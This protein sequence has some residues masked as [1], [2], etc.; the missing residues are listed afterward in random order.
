M[1]VLGQGSNSGEKTSFKQAWNCL[2]Q[3]TEGRGV[4]WDQAPT[5]CLPHPIKNTQ[6]VTEP[7]MCS[8]YMK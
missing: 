2:P 5:R 4:G 1:G 3:N 7:Q 6:Q 8:K